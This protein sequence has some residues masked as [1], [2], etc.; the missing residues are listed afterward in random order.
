[1]STSYKF[2][3]EIGETVYL[4]TDIEQ[5]Q[6]IVTGINISENSTL[7]RIMFVTTES[8]HYGFELTKERDIVKATS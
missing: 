5:H 4:K 2:E 1:M 7:F 3:F 6:R 8:W